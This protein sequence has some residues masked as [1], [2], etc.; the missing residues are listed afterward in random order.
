MAW[1]D[2]N[3]SETEDDK[4][5]EQIF[6]KKK[7][8]IHFCV[9]WWDSFEFSNNT[10]RKEVGKIQGWYSPRTANVVFWWPGLFNP[11]WIKYGIKRW[12]D[13]KSEKWHDSLLIST[14]DRRTHL[15][16]PEGRKW[17][18][19]KGIRPSFQW[20]NTIGMAFYNQY[21]NNLVPP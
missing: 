19:A 12:E 6:Y 21:L 9:Q 8:I 20:K 10:L 16:R 18:F 11:L 5:K 2:W 15:W 7:V 1:P 14:N 4:T 13:L 3:L 17:P